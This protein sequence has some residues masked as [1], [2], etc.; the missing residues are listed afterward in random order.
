MLY[1]ETIINSPQIVTKSTPYIMHV[2]QGQGSKIRRIV[3]EI[4][5]NIYVSLQVIIWTMNFVN[6]R[7]VVVAC[8]GFAYTRRSISVIGK[9]LFVDLELPQKSHILNT[10]DIIKAFGNTFRSCFRK[11]VIKDRYNLLGSLNE[12]HL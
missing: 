6:I 8:K 7:L 1:R 10:Q 4:R 3:T 2:S 11:V 12:P 9:P 5:T